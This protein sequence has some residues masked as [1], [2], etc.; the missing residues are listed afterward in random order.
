M[1]SKYAE[2]QNLFEDDGLSRK[3]EFMNNP[4]RGV[5]MADS[6]EKEEDPKEAGEEK[7]ESKDQEEDTEDQDKEEDTEDQDKEEDT[8]DQDTEE[9]TEDQDTEEDSS[10]EVPDEG[11]GEEDS[12]TTE[13]DAEEEQKDIESSGKKIIILNQYKRLS[14]ILGS[15]KDGS[16]DLINNAVDDTILSEGFILRDEI[17]KTIGQVDFALALDF[18]KTDLE[19]LE[20]LYTIIY[21]K[22]KKL[23]D[24][25]EKL[26]KTKINTES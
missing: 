22:I 21:E 7:P 8:E 4:F 15:L 26:A 14:G 6:D 16:I 1:T 19:R 13:E 9:D 25:L 20:E 10:D 23:V 2:F 3:D 5:F 24:F 12:A 17:N 18:E 11:K